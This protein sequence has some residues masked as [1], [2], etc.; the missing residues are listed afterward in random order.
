MT[1]GLL[2]ALIVLSLPF[3]PYG[4]PDESPET[5]AA[6]TA[7]TVPPEKANP[8][9]VARFQSPPTIDG[10][11]DDDVWKSAVVLKD[12]YQTNPGDN[13]APSRPTEV[14]LGYDAT[15]LYIAFRAWDEPGKI[16]AT[17][18]KRDQIFDDDF[19]GMFLDT[20]ND[21]RKAYALFFSPL[22]VQA[23]GIMTEGAEEDYS[24]DIVME[25][26]GLIGDDGYTVEVAIPF[27][28]LRYEAGEGKLWGAHFYRRI[29]RFDRELDSW[30]PNARDRS[31]VLDQ[32][33]HLTGLEGISTERTL[34]IIPSLT[35]SE[36]GRRVAAPLPGDSALL[37]S[38]GRLVNAP[39]GF[40]PGVSLKLGLTP[41][42]TLD[43]T[44]NPDF[45]Q[46]EAD[47]TVVTANQR[48]PIFFEEKRPFFLEGMDIFQTRLSTINTRAIVDPDVAAKL[49]GKVGRNTFGLLLASDAAPGNFT[50][51][52]RVD[53]E[54]LPTIGPLIDENALIGVL[55][56]KRDVGSESSLGLVA[57][58][59]NFEG[60]HNQLGGIDGRFKLD[61]KTI[62]TF[63]V[64]G[65]NSR[66]IFFDPDTGE[67]VFRTGN[68]FSY[69]WEYDYTS[70]NFGY[71][72]N[73][74]G[75]TSDY[76]A[77]VGFTRR[78]NFNFE[79]FFL[80][81]NSDPKPKAFLVNW[82]VVNFIGAGFDW[83]GRSREWNNGTRIQFNLKRQTFVSF[84]LDVGYERLFE[85]E[86][87][88]R[89]SETQAGA[90]FG[91]PERSAYNRAFSVFVESNPSEKFSANAFVGTI[92]N[93]FDLDLGA[94]ERYPRVSP[95]A[96]ANP[97]APLDP[98]IGHTFDVEAEITYKPT[99][100]LRTT[101]GYT[102]ARLVRGDTNRVAFDD[103][104]FSSR[105]TYQFTR[106]TFARARIDYDTLASS[107]RGQFL[108]GW[109]PSPGTS[110]YVGY[111][112]DLNY[113]GF[114]P[115]TNALEPGFRRNGRTFFVK[116]SYLL[117]YSL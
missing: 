24:L 27:K 96:L 88:T 80:R 74:T 79:N 12:F 53:P 112:D 89:R 10:R 16:R 29:Q 8:V 46:V 77:N 54:L 45:A 19:V 20:F 84:G 23:D 85:E 58:S 61:P 66:R 26:K 48:F 1:S 25:S 22:G 99:A 90:F 50:A 30:M 93:A 104:I 14:R 2:F 43:F 113:N 110:F 37:S 116:M 94:G 81:V 107:V 115:Y 117:R 76:R 62:F 109:T 7:V 4:A 21:R 71:Q 56:L 55:R 67:D 98:G 114:S 86:F 9:R 47:Q 87:G 108:L 69:Y 39:V 34:E 102:K 31:G 32:A 60:D 106:F 97:D 105:T 59:Y 70:R 15:T 52:E 78:T 5:G 91:G 72:L 28:S 44:V 64:T 95:A 51:E 33:G 35:L 36:T 82:R 92:R 13:I 65:S 63:E 57:T 41:S 38:A 18:P 103:N 49:T 83:Q 3:P 111:N 100:A 17:V 42:V 73:G 11:L 6:K 68:G 40:D 75:R 101:L